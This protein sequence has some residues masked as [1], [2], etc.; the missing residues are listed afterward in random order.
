MAM[1][2]H[3]TVGIF[4][5]LDNAAQAVDEICAS[6]FRIDDVSVI[7]QDSERVQEIADRTETS[8]G[9]AAVK[10]AGAGAAVG[11]LAGLLLGVT[12]VTIPGVGPLLAAGPLAALIGG[13][14][15]GAVVGG[16]IGALTSMGFSE[17][18][19]EEYRE[20]IREGDVLLA[21]STDHESEE[22]AEAILQSHGG[23]R[24]RTVHGLDAADEERER[25][26]ATA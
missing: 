3:T 1:G 22:S 8:A 7:A 11:G 13:A 19:A 23:E 18:E 5:N 17:E 24:V 21:V 16:I 2:E 4:S 10:G 9:N 12:A 6:G 15:T 25:E 20:R 26:G 14:A